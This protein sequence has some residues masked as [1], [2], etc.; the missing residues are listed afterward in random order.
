MVNSNVACRPN[1]LPFNQVFAT[2]PKI[3]HPQI[4]SMGD[5]SSM[6]LQYLN[7]MAGYKASSPSS[8]RQVANPSI[9][10]AYEC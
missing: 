10:L 8:G 1:T 4:L 5:R 7:V 6:E 9:C 2:H 3:G